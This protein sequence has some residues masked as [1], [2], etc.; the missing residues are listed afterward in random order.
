MTFTQVSIQILVIYE[1]K[2]RYY[3]RDLNSSFN[4]ILVNHERN[5][6][7]YERDL[8]SCFNPILVNHERNSRYYE[9][10]LNSCFNPILVNHERNSKYY[11]FFFFGFFQKVPPRRRHYL[12]IREQ[13]YWD[14]T[15][16]V[17]LSKQNIHVSSSASSIISTTITWL[18]YVLCFFW[19]W[20]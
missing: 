1:I 11:Q 8:N 15:W 18:L 9:R 4:Q 20:P 17:F 13:N 12:A 3:E 5:S 19:A 14:L 16:L 2:S 7:Y 10:D 6:R